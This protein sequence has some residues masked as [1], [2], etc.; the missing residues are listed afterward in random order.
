MII[1]H[2]L[3]KNRAASIASDKHCKQALLSSTSPLQRYTYTSRQRQ[4][5]T[6]LWSYEYVS[7]LLYF[8]YNYTS[9]EGKDVVFRDFADRS[10][11][12]SKSTFFYSPTAEDQQK[13]NN[14]Q[15]TQLMPKPVTAIPNQHK[16]SK[17][18]LSTHQCGWGQPC[19]CASR[20]R[21]CTCAIQLR[22][23]SSCH[24]GQSR[25]PD[26]PPPPSSYLQPTDTHKIRDKGQRKEYLR[27]R[28]N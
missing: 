3:Y 14:A 10:R 17:A 13:V 11:S 8:T 9:R 19:C 18:L 26:T 16:Q 7:V 20:R 15:N 23:R 6:K 27:T 1:Y 22:R 2:V 5:Q 4:K 24:Q 28:G 12:C 21:C 25:T